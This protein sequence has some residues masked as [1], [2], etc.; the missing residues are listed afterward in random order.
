MSL[1]LDDETI[2]G[3]R[4]D[5][6]KVMDAATGTPARPAP[7]DPEKPDQMAQLIAKHGGH[8]CLSSTVDAAVTAVRR[9]R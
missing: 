7:R 3:L 8:G 9:R 4:R 6:L 1:I 2:I 5:G